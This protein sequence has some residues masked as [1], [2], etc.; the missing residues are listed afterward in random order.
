[1]KVSIKYDEKTLRFHSIPYHIHDLEVEAE[2][3]EIEGDNYA[4]DNDFNGLFNSPAY[5]VSIYACKGEGAPSHVNLKKL[6]E[7]DSKI[8][9]D[10]IYQ[11]GCES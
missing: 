7:D 3:S 8:I 6:C 2:V 4:P 9:E 11:Y 5:D 10:L 1:M